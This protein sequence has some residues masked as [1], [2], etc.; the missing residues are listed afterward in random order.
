MLFD[1]PNNLIHLNFKVNYLIIIFNYTNNLI[2]IKFKV[3]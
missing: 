1:Y 3:N 2:F